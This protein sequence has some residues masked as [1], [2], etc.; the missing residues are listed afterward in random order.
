MNLIALQITSSSNVREEGEEGEKWA[1][2]SVRRPIKL[3]KDA[4]F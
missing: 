4:A 3:R 1:P 2:I